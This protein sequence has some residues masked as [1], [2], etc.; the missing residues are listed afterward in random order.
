MNRPV[1]GA[2]DHRLFYSAMLKPQCDFQMKYLFTVTLKAEMARLNDPG[3]YRADRHFVNLIAFDAKKVAHSGLYRLI[4][5][6]IPCVTSGLGAV[7]SDG[8]EPGVA[9]GL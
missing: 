9:D 6:A 8:L 1:V 3:V 2:A 4:Q 5:R 7:V